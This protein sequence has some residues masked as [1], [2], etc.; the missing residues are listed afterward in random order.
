MTGILTHH[1]HTAQVRADTPPAAHARGDVL[2]LTRLFVA[3]YARTPVNLLLLALVPVVFVIAVAGP[4]SKAAQILGGSAATMI[5]TASAGWAAAF[6][7]GIAM[8]FQVAGS[9]AGDTRLALAGLRPS[10]L[11][12]ARLLTGLTLATVAS[13]AALVALALRTG[14][15]DAERTIPGTLM[16][17]VIYLAIGAIVGAVSATP[18]NGTV[19]ILLIWLLDLIFG[20]AFGSADRLATRGLPTHFLTLWMIERP[21]GHSGRPGDLGWA[22]AWTAAA[23]VISVAVLRHTTAVKTGRARR[24]APGSLSTQF[25]T[26]LRLGLRDYARNRVLWVLL[27]LVPVIFVLGTFFTTADKYEPVTVTEDGVRGLRPFW[28]P[29]IHGPLMAPIA[30]AALAAI[31]GVFVTLDNRTGDQRLALAGYRPTGLIGARLAT[32]AVIAT[33]ATAAA[34]ATTATAFTVQRWPVFIAANL[35]LAAIYGLLGVVVALVFGR[36]G[37]VF[38]AF[39]IP[40]LDLAVG[41]SPMLNAAPPT[42]ARFT[43]GYGTSRVITDAALTADFDQTLPLAIALGWLAALTAIA[44]AVMRPR[45]RA[46]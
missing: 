20:P 38:M 31:A 21:S 8:Y 19:A 4:L 32:I 41:Q 23:V 6:L 7:A 13:A 26:G 33:L 14:L 18:V 29:D 34:V 42:W 36:V 39:L 15:G 28:L 5:P 11:V 25:R 3:D 10:T 45:T 37:G 43:P 30:V 40:F 12:A 35:L 2:A 44:V 24:H 22:L 27:V 9:R 1:R 46:G 16:F 17:A